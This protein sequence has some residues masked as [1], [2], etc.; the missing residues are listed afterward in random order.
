MLASVLLALLGLGSSGVVNG[1]DINITAYKARTFSLFA[2]P[3]VFGDTSTDAA[4]NE[5][6]EFYKGKL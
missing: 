2:L 6:L 5:T 4:Y 1:Q 3:K